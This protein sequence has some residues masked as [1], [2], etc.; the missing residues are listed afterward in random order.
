[1]CDFNPKGGSY[2]N[3]NTKTYPNKESKILEATSIED[4]EKKIEREIE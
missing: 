3:N 2:D 1:V 4:M